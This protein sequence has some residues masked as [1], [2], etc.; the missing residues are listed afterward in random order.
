MEKNCG[1]SINK[2]ILILRFSNFFAQ[3][4]LEISNQ[5]M[6][7][8][9]VWGLFLSARAVTWT[10]LQGFKAAD[11]WYCCHFGIPQ[12]RTIKSGING[13]QSG[14]NRHQQISFSMI[15]GSLPYIV[16]YVAQFY[17]LHGPKGPEGDPDYIFFT[18]NTC[19]ATFVLHIM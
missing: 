14:P 19:Q 9:V 13:C 6:T 7:V 2:Q 1:F 10:M 12:P 11:V 16:M 17:P 8:L 3:T 4:L 18:L 5:I 15:D